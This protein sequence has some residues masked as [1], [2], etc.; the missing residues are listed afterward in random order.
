MT[1]F[2]LQNLASPTVIYIRSANYTYLGLI[3][4]NR[5]KDR[6]S[7]SNKE[8]QGYDGG[9]SFPSESAKWLEIRE[10]TAHEKL[11]LQTC[12]KEKKFIHKEQIAIEEYSIFD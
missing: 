5:W 4:E 3:E 1:F 9:W 2:D 10:A 6:I 8:F 12:I 11:W 7:I